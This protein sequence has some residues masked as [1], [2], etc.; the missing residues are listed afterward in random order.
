MDCYLCGKNSARVVVEV[1]GGDRY[2]VC[3]VCN[4]RGLYCFTCDKPLKDGDE[5]H[6]FNSRSDEFQ[7]EACVEAALWAYQESRVF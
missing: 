4:E 2:T 6:P 5:R 1:R 7:C 3:S